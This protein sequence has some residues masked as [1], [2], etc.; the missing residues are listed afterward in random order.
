MQ[1]S[2]ENAVAVKN[3]LQTPLLIDPSARALTWLCEHERSGAAAVEVTAMHEPRFAN[4]LELAVRFGKVRACASAPCAVC[5][6]CRQDV[7]QPFSNASLLD[8]LKFQA[9]QLPQ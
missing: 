7:S 5:W 6:A 1:V 8:T 4:T 2:I 9:N 3:T